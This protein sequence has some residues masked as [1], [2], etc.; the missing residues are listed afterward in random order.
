MLSDATRFFFGI[1]ILIGV[2]IVMGMVWHL[3]QIALV[4]HQRAD[5]E[6]ERINAKLDAMAKVKDA[7]K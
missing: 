4:H 1:A 3:W 5:F 6:W 7:G 2:F